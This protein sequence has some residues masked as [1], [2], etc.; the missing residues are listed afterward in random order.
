MWAKQCFNG[1]NVGIDHPSNHHFFWGGINYIPK[2]LDLSLGCPHQIPALRRSTCLDPPTACATMR[3][4][5]TPTVSKDSA[6]V[7]HRST[8]GK[9][10][11]CVR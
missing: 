7:Q 5:W 10:A 11:N 2:V 3:R 4:A 6:S 9:L 8:Y 1:I